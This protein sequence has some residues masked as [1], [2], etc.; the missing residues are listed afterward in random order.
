WLIFCCNMFFTETTGIYFKVDS[1]LDTVRA[2]SKDDEL[3]IFSVGVYLNIYH[4]VSVVFTIWKAFCYLSHDNVM[5]LNMIQSL[6]MKRWYTIRIWGKVYMFL[7][8][9]F[10]LSYNFIDEYAIEIIS[11]YLIWDLNYILKMPHPLCH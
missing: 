6:M 10:A 3:M 11:H 1:D 5:I 7:Y 4:F 2:V 8:S 9:L